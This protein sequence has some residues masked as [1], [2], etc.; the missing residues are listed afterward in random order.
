MRNILKKNM[1]DLKEKRRK[2]KKQLPERL[3]K[4]KLSKRKFD[5][6]S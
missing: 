6:V 2:G 3:K 1:K 4:I 5:Y